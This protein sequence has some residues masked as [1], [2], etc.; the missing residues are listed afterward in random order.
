M[1]YFRLGKY[2]LSKYC[3]GTWSLGGN[4]KNNLS[5][6]NIS[7]KESKQLLERAFKSGINFFDTANVYGEAEKRLG[8]CFEKIRFKVFIA[9][10]VGC[11]SFK[12][13]IDL[14][15]GNVNK[16]IDSSL[17][18]LRT[19]YLDIVQLYNPNPFDKNLKSCLSF[20]K[21][22]KK[23]GIIRFIGLSLKDPKDYLYLRKLHKFDTVQFNFNVLD[24]RLFD[25]NIFKLMKKDRIKLL[26]RTVLNFGIFT[27]EFISKK[28]IIFNK[29]D[30]RIKWNTKQIKL[31]RK[32]IHQIKKLSKR[33]IENTC[34]KFCNSFGISSIIIGATKNNHI[35]K[36]VSP[37]NST[38]LNN[39][40]IKKI[41][42]IY[43]NFSKNYFIKPKFKIKSH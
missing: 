5:Y 18:N 20:L 2:K 8:N 29:N 13:K 35:D 10:K 11:S 27:E 38:K 39:D 25:R 33:D 23:Q 14:S 36:A 19:N 42:K 41:K 4:K 1:R 15:V 26:A 31:W 24:L 17:K 32:Y 28:K 7:Y 34:Y 40:E 6:G 9:S 30:H 16:Q 22:K 21:K 37:K 3:L 12:R 43:N